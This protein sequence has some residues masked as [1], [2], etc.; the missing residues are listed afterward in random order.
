LGACGKSKFDFNN[1]SVIVPN[2]SP[3]SVAIGVQEFREGE[4]HPNDYMM[5][6]DGAPLTTRDA[7]IVTWYVGT[8]TRSFDTFFDHGGFFLPRA[9]DVTNSVKVV[10]GDFKTVGS[11]LFQSVTI[12]NTG[13]TP[14]AVPLNLGIFDGSQPVTSFSATL[15]HDP[16]PIEYGETPLGDGLY[17]MFI[18]DIDPFG[19]QRKLGIGPDLAPGESVTRTLKFTVSNP[20]KG[21]TYST[22]VFSGPGVFG[23][24]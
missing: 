9:K 1:G 8:S 6:F 23:N 12:T 13:R 2:G 24:Q 18:S 21:L 22:R 14:L 7:R 10:A 11:T 20:A 19:L 5:L 17:A 3:Q 15:G 16:G 4:E